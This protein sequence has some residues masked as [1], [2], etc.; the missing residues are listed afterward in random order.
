MFERN[1]LVEKSISERK[2][3]TV[4]C[5]IP[6]IVHSFLIFKDESE[7]KDAQKTIAEKR[8]PHSSF[9]LLYP[10]SGRKRSGIGSFM[11]HPETRMNDSAK[12]NATVRKGL[13]FPSLSSKDSVEDDID[14]Y[15]EMAS[16]S[17]KRAI[18]DDD[19]E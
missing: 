13:A 4:K 3:S 7:K 17:W 15:P 16:I 19:E 6:K 2:I 9:A 1:V 8:N 18:L 12:E 11:L 14:V 10:K 5:L